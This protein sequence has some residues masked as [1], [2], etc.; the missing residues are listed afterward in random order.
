MFLLL[1]HFFDLKNLSHWGLNQSMRFTWL[2]CTLVRIYHILFCRYFLTIH[3]HF[4]LKSTDIIMDCIQIPIDLQIKK[5]RF[6]SWLCKWL[7][8]WAPHPTQLHPTF[9]MLSLLKRDQISNS[10]LLVSQLNFPEDNFFFL[11]EVSLPLTIVMPA[12]PHRGKDMENCRKE[13]L[14]ALRGC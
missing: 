2:P 13:E 6:C 3:F 9:F 10:T 14:A 7:Q 12:R 1:F 8:C 4:I 5:L 11:E